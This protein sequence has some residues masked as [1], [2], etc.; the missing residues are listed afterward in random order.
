MQCDQRPV[1]SPESS[2][3]M[4]S[5]SIDQLISKYYLQK[6]DWRNGTEQFEGL[7][8][9]YLAR[10]MQVLEVGPG[11]GGR[12]SEF[13]SSKSKAVHGLDIDEEALANPHL[14]T[15]FVY[16]GG[17]F[18]IRSDT[19][20]AAVADYV[21]EHLEHPIL[22]FSEISRVL[23]KGGLFIF[24][25]PNLWHYVSL[26]AFV[27]PHSFHNRVA[28]KVRALDKSAHD[29]YPTYFKANTRKQVSKLLDEVGLEIVEYAMVEKEPSYLKFS[30]VAFRLGVAYERIV[31]SSRRFEVARANIFCVARKT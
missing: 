3:S 29:P 12:T 18:P 17:I 13:I 31:N 21:L 4:R 27:T 16:D 20:E 7:L 1:D 6:T 23:K 28:K 14:E 2:E 8:D 30:T 19:Y 11:P 25:T 24:R 22:T 10:E 15:S 26:I 5:Q 9:K